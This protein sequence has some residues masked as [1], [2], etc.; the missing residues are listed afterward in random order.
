MKLSI[1]IAAYNEENSILKCLERV[2]AVQLPHHFQKEIIVVDDGS[3]DGT[4]RVLDTVKNKYKV[5]KHAKNSGKG[6]AIRTALASATGEYVVTQDAD[7]ENDPNDLASMLEKMIDEK[8][9]V[10]YGSRRLKKDNNQQHKSF[11]IGGV[12]LS[13]L[14][15]ILY[16][17][18][19]TDEPTCYKMFKTDFL[20]SL[21]LKARRFE[22]CPEVTALTSLQGIKI[23]E[24]PISY[25]PRTLK[26]GK[27]IRLK[28]GIQAVWTLIKYRMTAG[29]W[30]FLVALIARLLLLWANVHANHSFDLAIHGQDGYYDIAKNMYTGH[31]FSWDGVHP[32]PFQVPLYPAFLSASL[33]LFGNFAPIVFLQ[34]IIASFIPVLAMKLSLRFSS[35]RKIALAAAW[36]IALEPNFIFFS[37]IFYTETLFIF[38]LLIFLLVFISYLSEGK[39]QAHIKPL[40]WSAIILGIAALTKTA[41]QFLPVLLVPLMWWLL[42]K[43]LSPKKLFLHGVMFMAIFMA[44]LSPWLYRNHRVFGVAGMTVIPTYNL[45]TCI[46][47]SV[48]ALSNHTS[49]ASEYSNFVGN[50]DIGSTLDFKS[51]SQFRNKAMTIVLKHP[52]QVIEMSAI[53]VFTFFTHDGAL[54]I[55]ENAGMFPKVSLS[56]PALTYLLS[57]PVQFIKEASG[58]IVSP[59]I[60]VLALRLFWILITALFIYGAYKLFR[61]KSITPAIAL[62][63]VLVIYFAA[64]TPSNGL[65]VNARFRMPVEPIILIIAFMGIGTLGGN[66]KSE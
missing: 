54:T 62:G 60:L 53:N 45:Y 7:L 48:L 1:L 63:L 55:L 17:Q 47:P 66:K 35:S 50:L 21:P 20:K 4:G 29:V 24:I 12:A 39:Y 37:F 25:H 41:A 43:K 3:T 10:L 11:Y 42:C 57:S 2:E 22:Y 65:T 16:K 23:K 59:F 14:A 40:C 33:F 8:L 52:K 36:I 28:D 64:T 5:L 46:V 27:K 15:N 19:I 61:T 6:S 32:S 30:I 34:I 9:T 56:K 26:E 44:V 13:W 51:E 18:R 31:G 49:F 38:L 58:F